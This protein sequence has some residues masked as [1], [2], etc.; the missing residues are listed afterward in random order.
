MSSVCKI[1]SKTVVFERTGPCAYG[2][3]GRGLSIAI[4]VEVSQAGVE[5]K[6][7]PQLSKAGAFCLSRAAPFAVPAKGLNH[8]HQSIF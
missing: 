3:T 8:H 7:C 2:K 5:H 1:S 6:S 4:G